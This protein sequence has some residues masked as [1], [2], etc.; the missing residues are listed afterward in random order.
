MKTGLFIFLIAVQ[1]IIISLLSFQ[2]YQK[3]KNILGKKSITKSLPKKSLLF[4]S[5]TTSS[6]ANN[7]L[8][9]N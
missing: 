1:I 2:I 4:Y 8:S 6:P 7:K 3:Q 9:Q 5:K